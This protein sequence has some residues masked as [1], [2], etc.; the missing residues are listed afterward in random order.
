MIII[1]V[2]KNIHE[3]QYTCE[4]ENSEN[5][6]NPIKHNINLQVEGKKFPNI[7][8][9]QTQTFIVS[10]IN[11]SPNI[12]YPSVRPFQNFIISFT[13]LC[14]HM[15][16]LSDNSSL[17]FVN[18]LLFLQRRGSD[19]ERVIKRSLPREKELFPFL[20]QRPVQLLESCLAL[21]FG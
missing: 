16:V 14:L 10:S 20:Y 18:L 9:L 19:I 11:P 7:I 17:Q 2:Q 12:S 6:G 1:T 4:A 21:T 5:A 15:D 8:V 3:G 13:Y